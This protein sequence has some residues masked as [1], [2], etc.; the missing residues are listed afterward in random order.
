MRSEESLHSCAGRDGCLRINS[1]FQWAVTSQNDAGN[2]KRITGIT[3]DSSRAQ[4]GFYSPYLN[5]WTYI[6]TSQATGNALP[7]KN[8]VYDESIS[9][10]AINVYGEGWHYIRVST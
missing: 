4:M 5:D 3:Y 9:S 7:I 1:S 2:G 6:A 10:L 8:I